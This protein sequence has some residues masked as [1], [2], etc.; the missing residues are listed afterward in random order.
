MKLYRNSKP[1]WHS[2]TMNAGKQLSVVWECHTVPTKTMVNETG[3]ALLK[4]CGNI[5]LCLPRHWWMKRDGHFW[6]GVG[7]SYCAHQDSG[8]WNGTGTFEMVW[9]YHT[10]LTKT[11]VDEQGR[12]PLKWCE[13][14]ILCPPR[15]WWMKQ[16][17]HLWNGV[18]VSYCAHQDNGG[19]NGT[20]NFEMVWEYRT[21]PTKTMV[22]ETGRALLKWC[23]NIIL[24][25]PRHWWMKRDGHFWNGVGVSYCAHQDSGGWNGTGTFEM[26]WEYH[27]VLTKTL[28]DEQGRA[29]LKW[30]ESIILCPPRQWWMK[31][32]GHL[33]NGVGVSYCAHQDNG[34]WNGT[35]N[36]EMVWEYRTVPTKTMVDETGRAPL[37]WCESIILCLPRQWWIKRDGHLWNERIHMAVATSS[38]YDIEASMSYRNWYLAEKIKHFFLSYSSGENIACHIGIDTSPINQCQCSSINRMDHTFVLGIKSLSVILNP[39]KYGPICMGYAFYLTDL[40]KWCLYTTI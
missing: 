22:D 24:C 5:I 28:V 14:I 32:D 9:E 23:G 16:D 40:V 18:G 2:R 13:S 6:N 35:G 15:Q 12:A 25:L 37:K 1:I 21:V 11:L 8:G 29:P 30:C 39:M 3:R 20:G 19:W 4:W 27:T 26:V 34:G 38:R 17:G 10:V 36:F 31:Q 33:W 7:V